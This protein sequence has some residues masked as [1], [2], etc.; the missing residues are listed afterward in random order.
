METSTIESLIR[1]EQ[2]RQLPPCP[3]SL[4]DKVL[5]CV[6]RSQSRPEANGSFDWLLSLVADLPGK[7]T[8]LAALALVL[9]LSAST[10]ALV[11]SRQAE[12]IQRI[13]LASNS[14]DFGVFK[15]TPILNFD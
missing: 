7:G 10:S 5:R 6:R 8:V 3:R 11:A 14:L 1:A 13:E 15:Q 9:L 4:E 12:D 2:A